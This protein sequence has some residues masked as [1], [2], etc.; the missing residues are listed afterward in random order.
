MGQQ[1]S[2]NSRDFR[3]KEPWILAIFT[4]ILPKQAA[5]IS[6]CDISS[7]KMHRMKCEEYNTWNMTYEIVSIEYN[8]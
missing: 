5:Y 2:A 1:F 7:M 3:Q 6:S 8:M 4:Q